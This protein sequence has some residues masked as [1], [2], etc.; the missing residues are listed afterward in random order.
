M[1]DILTC[2]SIVAPFVAYRNRGR[3]AIAEKKLIP[4]IDERKALVEEN[5]RRKSGKLE[6]PVSLTLRSKVLDHGPLTINPG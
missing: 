1:H 6:E 4:I 2:R 3:I 5:E